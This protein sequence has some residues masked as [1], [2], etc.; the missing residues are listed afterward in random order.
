MIQAS[1]DY[2]AALSGSSRTFNVSIQ[3]D[4]EDIDG[5][6]QTVD[7]Y[8]GSSPETISVG[9]IYIPYFTAKIAN[10][11]TSLDDQDVTLKVG[12]KLASGYFQYITI[13]KYHIS[14]SQNNYGLSTVKGVGSAFWKL[15]GKTLP[16]RGEAGGVSNS[17]YALLADVRYYG[18]VD[19]ISDFPYSRLNTTVRIAIRSTQSPPTL[20]KVLGIIAALMGGFV[21]EDYLGRIV[22][23]E[24]ASG[25]TLSYVADRFI[26]APTFQGYEYEI[27][28]VKCVIHDNENNQYHP[29][30]YS[31]GTVNYTFSNKYMT[32]T[33]FNA[34]AETIIGL[35]YYPASLPIALGDPRIDPWDI[36]SVTD[37]DGVTREVFPLQ[38]HHHF[39]GGLSTDIDA[40]RPSTAGVQ[41]GSDT[42]STSNIS[43]DVEAAI[44]SAVDALKERTPPVYFDTKANWDAQTDL[45]GE[46]HAIYIYTDY[47][48]KDG[49]NIAGIKI[50]DGSAYLIDNPFL[51]TIYYDHIQDMD[52]HITSAER[53]FWNNKVRAYYSITDRETLV[54]TNN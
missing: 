43:I 2:I 52:M 8:K 54:L 40:E 41:T 18:G 21:T 15:Q 34:M 42:G 37:M 11:H 50:G 22:I 48:E 9:A 5:E 27:T 38:I 51:D 7:I 33:L 36:L 17:P 12:V 16:H 4:G 25:S 53:A 30:S 26:K 1:E 23:K 29:A 49:Q 10:L 45:V 14:E 24:Y 44:A 13:G 19:V 20:Q 3:I 35:S 28:G 46:E 31:A 32:E 47:Q 39:D 6:I